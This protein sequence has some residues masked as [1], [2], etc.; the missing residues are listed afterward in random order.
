MLS[1]P[2]PKM[3]SKAGETVGEVGPR[4]SLAIQDGDGFPP[5]ERPPISNSGSSHDLRL[6]TSHILP[7]KCSPILGACCMGMTN[8]YSFLFEVPRRSPNLRA[9]VRL[10]SFWAPYLK[11]FGRIPTIKVFDPS[12]VV[13]VVRKPHE[14]KTPP[15]VG[16]LP[17]P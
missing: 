8:G 5:K 6:L 16:F 3:L 11:L 12:P 2:Q 14:H 13:F 17:N 15:E 1:L 4:L 9:M 10:S 7:M